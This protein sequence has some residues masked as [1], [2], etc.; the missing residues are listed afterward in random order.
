MKKKLVIMVSAPL[1]NR[2]ASHFC[3][4][5]L[6]K[7]FDLEYWDCSL[8]AY[9]DFKGIALE[10]DYVRTPQ[11]F[12]E[13]KLMLKA[14][15]KDTLIVSDIHLVKQ[16]YGFHKMVSRLFK[17][18]IYVNFWSNAPGKMDE[19]ENAQPTAPKKKTLKQKIYQIGWLQ[20]LIKFVRY[21]GDERFKRFY[22]IHK[23]I[24]ECEKF[25]QEEKDC[26]ILY[27]NHV[28]TCL[29]HHQYSI[30]HP[31]YEKYLQIKEGQRII[32]KPF[33]VFIDEYFP[34]HPDF[35]EINP[36]IDCDQIAEIYYPS[37]NRIFDIIEKQTGMPVVIAAHPMADY[38]NNPFNGREI[39]MYKTAELVRDTSYV[40]M[41]HGF[42]VSYV[43]LF[44][45]PMCF[46]VNEGIRESKYCYENVVINAQM[47]GMPL[48]DSDVV[49]ETDAIFSKFPQERKNLYIN[50]FFDLEIKKRN[51]EL[52]TEYLNQIYED[53][54]KSLKK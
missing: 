35:P 51:G 1:T 8:V 50:R 37:M 42:C 48:I 49:K 34:Y 22:A 29:P 53:V 52:L 10:R 43:A 3:T 2:W 6:S 11:T 9:P 47:M 5:E 14:L 39:M 12:A 41:H 32:E 26:E 54:A 7:S 13:F 33:V 17:N 30:N 16:N 44:D 24:R 46:I 20:V 31:D 36:E 45:K 21:A 23:H 27:T 18:R 15:P 38:S 40:C 19:Q 28:I 25:V 4:D